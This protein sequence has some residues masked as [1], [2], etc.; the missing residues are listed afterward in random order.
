MTRGCR[1]GGR[2]GQWLGRPPVPPAEQPHGRRHQQRADQGG[3]DRDGHDH[4]DAD[5]LDGRGAA[6]GEAADHDD[7]QQR[8][9]GDDAARA[10]QA[11]R[12]RLVLS[13]VA[14]HSSRTRESRKT[15]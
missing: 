15:S 10:L 7:Q 2:G 5:Q 11:E 3:V 13:P 1:I 9:R 12:H 14:S 4:A 8:G 6:R